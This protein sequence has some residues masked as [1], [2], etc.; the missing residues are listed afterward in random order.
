MALPLGADAEMDEDGAAGIDVHVGALEGPEPRP[1]D[2]RA[3]PD[4]DRP[5][6]LPARRLLGAPVRILEPLEQPIEG[7]T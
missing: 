4:A 3:E 2:V 6:R 5:R 1:L 7:V